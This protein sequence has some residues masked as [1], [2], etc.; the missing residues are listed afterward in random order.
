MYEMLK[1]GGKPGLHGGA[2]FGVAWKDLMPSLRNAWNSEAYD[3]DKRVNRKVYE[4][5]AMEL[6]ASDQSTPIP[7]LRLR[8][9]LTEATSLLNSIAEDAQAATNSL[10]SGAENADLSNMISGWNSLVAKI[11]P[12]VIGPVNVGMSDEDTNALHN[13]VSNTLLQPLEN[14]QAAAAARGADFA[15][16][17]VITSK[18]IAKNILMQVQA[19]YYKAVPFAEGRRVRPT[20]EGAEIPQ[21]NLPAPTPY[22]FAA[23]YGPVSQ[24]A[25]PFQEQGPSFATGPWLQRVQPQQQPPGRE[26]A[27]MTAARNVLGPIVRKV[28]AK[29][30][31]QDEPPV[32]R[33]GD[34]FVEEYGEQYLGED[35]PPQQRQQQQPRLSF[36]EFDRKVQALK[37]PALDTFKQYFDDFKQS[38]KRYAP[39]GAAPLPTASAAFETVIWNEM[40]PYI[41]NIRDYLQYN[42]QSVDEAVG[43][44]NERLNR[45]LEAE[46]TQIRHNMALMAD[47]FR[48]TPEQKQQ[49]AEAERRSR[50]EWNAK[51]AEDARRADE[52]RERLRQEEEQRHKTW[53]ANEQ[54]RR[55]DA[56]AKTAARTKQEEAEARRQAAEASEAPPPREG[57]VRQQPQRL[58]PVFESV[59]TVRAK[60][61]VELE[62]QRTL[63]KQLTQ[64]IA[65]KNALLGKLRNPPK[66]GS[67]DTRRIQEVVGQIGKLQKNLS[68]AQGKVES[69]TR[70]LSGKGRAA[71]KGRWT[72]YSG[73]VTQPAPVKAK[74][75]GGN[76]RDTPNGNTE[77][78][79]I[80]T[81]KDG[82]NALP[83]D[84]EGN[85]PNEL[86]DI[87]TK[88]EMIGGEMREAY[89]DPD[90]KG[91]PKRWGIERRIP[92]LR[93]GYVNPKEKY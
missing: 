37:Q 82:Y 40:Q 23:P 4:R 86:G 93:K 75:R 50:A 2:A 51:M 41:D 65:D 31:R 12:L 39:R 25:A 48:K 59:Q 56:A 70:E 66:K 5:S 55:E 42:F 91:L 21:A 9:V 33:E 81:N 26:A 46:E 54:R 29:I 32:E 44:F 61:S 92:K 38:F 8:A 67:P 45:Q 20:F 1:H 22:G 87:A 43:V 15:G 17:Y 35:E 83:F 7:P 34:P 72:D 16:R 6:A 64:E 62:Q 24:Q 78:R 60:H 53:T 27:L 3:E 77:S 80:R 71:G 36:D 11:N 57:R 30:G 79:A 10:D 49:E 74:M 14:L 89:L 19:K 28:A 88:D 13:L 18:D 47:E 69:L 76:F 52:S 85:D 58:D 68:V 90:W 63:V 73:P 84:D